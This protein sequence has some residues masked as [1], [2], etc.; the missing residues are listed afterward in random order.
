MQ[1]LK[2][3][4]RMQM[5]LASI[6]AFPESLLAAMPQLSEKPRLGFATK[7][8]TWNPGPNVCNFTVTLGLQAVVVENGVRKTYRARY[9]SPAA[10]RFL[11]ED[12]LGFLGGFNL[13]EYAGDSPTNFVD[14]SGMKIGVS[15]DYMDYLTAISYLEGSSI[16]AGIIQQLE[17][18][19]TVYMVN[20]NDAGKGGDQIEQGQPTK[21]DWLPHAGNCG[22][23]GKMQSPALQ[24]MHELVHLLQYQQGRPRFI[25]VNG[26][27]YDNWEEADNQIVNAIAQQLGEPTKGQYPDS[28]GQPDSFPIP[29]GGKQCGCKGQ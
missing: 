18:S 4:N 9:Y 11:S 22:K 20:A 8:T 26:Q 27:L 19:S 16:A 25:V 2:S 6:P 15:G 17:D 5:Q 13:Y 21:A 29:L 10:G 28:T 23:D 14:P 12:P 24:L 7:K 1:R 3:Y